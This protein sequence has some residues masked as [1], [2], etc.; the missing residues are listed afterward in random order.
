VHDL[1]EIGS[2]RFKNEM[3]MIIHQNIGMENSVVRGMGRVQVTKKSLFIKICRKYVF[4]FYT[5]LNYMVERSLK[6]NS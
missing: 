5:T 6:F 1:A 3:I 4:T 2:W